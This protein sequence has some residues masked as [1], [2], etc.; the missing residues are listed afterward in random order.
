MSSTNVA[1]VLTAGY[2]LLPD[3]FEKDMATMGITFEKASRGPFSIYSD[4]R[5]Q[6]PVDDDPIPGAKLKVSVPSN[7]EGAPAL[8]D[9]D[10]ATRWSSRKPQ[11]KGMA[12]EIA[13]PQPTRLTKIALYY[14]FYYQDRALSLTILVRAHGTWR[15][16]REN[17][18]CDMDPCEFINGHP[19]WGNQLQ[20]IRLPG[21]K[22]DGLRIEIDQPA[23]GRDWT[24]G[25]I[26][27]LAARQQ[28]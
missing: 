27:L 3:Q 2:R 18:A 23:S 13:L 22:T 5:E 26:R 19:D 24:I 6:N 9:G 15:I 12:I 14:N 28:G 11:Q 17:I 21:D 8:T 10:Y 25:E 20:S 16:V 7:P 1:Y 4:F